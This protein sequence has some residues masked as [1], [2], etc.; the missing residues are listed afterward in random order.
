MDTHGSNKPLNTIKEK[1]SSR[2]SIIGNPNHFNIQK[3]IIKEEEN[4]EQ[5]ALRE[6][7]D[8]ISK[9]I[10]EIK[11]PLSLV[12]LITSEP[13]I[14]NCLKELDNLLLRNLSLITHL[15]MVACGKEDIKSIEIGISTIS[16]SMVSDG[17]S[18]FSKQLQGM[19][20]DPEGSR[21]KQE[22]L[23]PAVNEEKRE[24]IIELD[25]VY[26]N[27]LYFCLDFKY[28]WKL[29]RECGLLSPK[30]SLAM[31]DRLYFQNMDNYVEM[32]FIPELLEKK[33][34]KREEFDKIY[35]Y[36]Y[37]KIQKSK[38]IFDNKYK[39]QIEQN[40]ILLYGAVKQNDTQEYVPKEKIKEDYNFHEEKNIILLRYFYEFLIRVAYLR[41][42]EDPKLPIQNRVK[43][44]IDVLKNYFRG[45]R[46][47]SLDISINASIII[48]PKLKNFNTILDLFISNH[49]ITLYKIFTECYAY[50]CGTYK[51]YKSYDMTITHNFFYNNIILNTTHL[52][53]I[54]GSKMN[55]I[56]LISIYFKEK[57]F[58]GEFS[59]EEIYEYVEDIFN[60][61]MIFREFCELIFFISR[62]YF[63]FYK[64]DTEEEDSK[65][66]VLTKE[67]MEKKKEAE[68]K[69][70]KKRKKTKSEN[71]DIYMAIINDI[72]EAK[73]LFMQKPKRNPVTQYSF[74]KLKTHFTI[75]K[76]QEME[77]LRKLEEERKE[78]DRIRYNLERKAFKDEDIN[79]HKE[80]NE[81]KSDS[82]D[83][84]EY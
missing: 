44:L 64:I 72:I 34:K 56:D 25:N 3:E 8:K 69:N 53:E 36:I 59:D 67:E 46:K 76:L 82:E 54:F 17:K 60:Y 52:S 26:N 49:Y 4:L 35:D 61:E 79:V 10:D 50:T 40:S 15:Y 22:E 24:K 19:K 5:K 55:Y 78:R 77:R 6:K 39:S 80:D 14:K 21:N 7:R 48:D 43:I 20:K 1:K 23:P 38:N 51:P 42:N 62:K 29:I 65:G 70:K 83:N 47:T 41:F 2:G 31:I 28:F 71:V 30:L 84:S 73:N 75:E 68:R 57:K 16:R 74:P 81:E 33:N 58:Q 32:F 13:E 66:R 9:N 27:D 11:I 45:K 12:D 63:H 18:F 37:Q